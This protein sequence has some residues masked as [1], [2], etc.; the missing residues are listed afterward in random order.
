VISQLANAAS[1]AWLVL[2]PPLP[3]AANAYSP[4]GVDAT[5]AISRTILHLP[6]SLMLLILR[7]H[8]HNVN[9]ALDRFVAHKEEW[10]SVNACPMVSH[11]VRAI[12]WREFDKI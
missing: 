1:H 10:R 11:C 6:V 12:D 8:Q 5:T 3:T 2:V 4:D 9:V 7:A